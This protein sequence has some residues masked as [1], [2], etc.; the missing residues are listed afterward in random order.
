MDTS[1]SLI[2][3]KRRKKFHKSFLSLI[4]ASC[5]I[6]FVLFPL[7]VITSFALVL[8]DNDA[9]GNETAI[10]FFVF[11]T[12][13][14]I[15][16]CPA[17]YFC[18]C[19]TIASR[20]N[21]FGE[22]GLGT[23]GRV[24][25]S[26]GLIFTFASF[27]CTLLFVSLYVTF[28]PP[29]FTNANYWRFEVIDDVLKNV[30]LGDSIPRDKYVYH[31][32]DGV[33]LNSTYGQSKDDNRDL[34]YCVFPASLSFSANHSI[35]VLVGC[36]YWDEDKSCADVVPWEKRNSDK[37]DSC[38]SNVQKKYLNGTVGIFAKSG[39]TDLFQEKDHWKAAKEDLQDNAIDQGYDFVIVES[40]LVLAIFSEHQYDDLKE[41]YRNS[42][43]F[44]CVTIISMTAT[45]LICWG[46]IHIITIRFTKMK[47]Q[48]DALNE[49]LPLFSSSTN[50]N[51]NKTGAVGEYELL[52]DKEQQK[53]MF[54]L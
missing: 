47:L 31:L 32:T 9:S 36:V 40:P 52:E 29:V 39:Y 5:L 38:F 48:S 53:G 41:G 11:V 19:F 8:Q 21:T 51:A 6:F 45:C 43:V 3:R 4:V 49:S 7:F 24:L 16:F 15:F 27:L 23:C 33:V 22:L 25:Y 46:V 50:L 26:D 37:S 30:S 1:S 14:L 10:Y 20:K 44:G 34:I 42:F 2:R 17:L 54:D 12:L 18:C 28:W 13:V 35:E